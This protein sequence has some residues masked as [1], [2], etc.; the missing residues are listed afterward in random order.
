MKETGMTRRVDELGRV[1]IPKEIR[2]IL[3][4]KE[5]TPLEI[6]VEGDTLLFKKYSVAANNKQEIKNIG[7]TLFRNTGLSVCFFDGSEKIL[8]LSQE[9]FNL[10]FTDAFFHKFE[11]RQP[12]ECDKKSCLEMFGVEKFAFCAP[13][14]KEGDLIGIFAVFSKEEISFADKKL[15]MFCCD[16]LAQQIC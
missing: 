10:N 7:K 11:M 4:I 16:V 15:T 13:L 1:V 3:K 6:F 5:G 14:I 12:F 2:T 9:E 8:F